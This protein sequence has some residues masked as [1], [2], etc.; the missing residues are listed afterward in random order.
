M[1]IC[2]TIHISRDRLRFELHMMPVANF[3]S[4]VGSHNGHLA[5]KTVRSMPNCEDSQ[6]NDSCT[7]I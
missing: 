6:Q 3:Q 2:V 1:P 5:V 7:G 4:A